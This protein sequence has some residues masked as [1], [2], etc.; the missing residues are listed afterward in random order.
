M[1]RRVLLGVIAI[2]ALA[3]LVVGVTYAL[4]TAQQIETATFGSGTVEIGLNGE[5][6]GTIGNM[7]PGDEVYQDFTVSNPG[8]LAMFYK[9]VFSPPYNA[10]DL[11]DCDGE[12]SLHIRAELQAGDYYIPPSGTNETVRVYAELPLAADNNCQD[13]E[14]PVNIHFFAWQAAHT[15]GM[16]AVLLE[17]KNAASDWQTIAD[18]TN[19][20]SLHYDESGSGLHVV[21]HGYGLIEG[22]SYQVTLN[23]PGICTAVDDLIAGGTPGDYPLYDVGYW[24]DA[25][26]GYIERACNPLNLA[27]GGEGIYNFAWVQADGDGSI[28]LDETIATQPDSA[29]YPALPPGDYENVKFLIKHLDGTPPGSN[30]TGVLMETE[31]LT[32]TMN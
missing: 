3:A 11:W 8:T 29:T 10:G 15:E 21:V 5:W 19:W 27:W 7:A 28:S 32:F 4:F 12:N 16:T 24:N 2:V 25:A 13:E 9:V 26:S 30:W 20:G 17:D 31:P 18:V 22:D 23:G 6:V 14:G 1:R